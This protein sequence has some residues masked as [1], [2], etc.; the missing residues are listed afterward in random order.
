MNSAAIMLV[1]VAIMSFVCA[2]P[3]VPL[4]KRLAFRCDATDV[5][6]PGH[7]HNRPTAQLG[8]LAILAAFMLPLIVI[9]SLPLWIGLCATAMLVLGIVDD[10]WIL[11]PRKKLAL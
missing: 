7:P 6:G 4:A 9:E 3:G 1:A 11:A 2:L 5:P 8:G 10:L